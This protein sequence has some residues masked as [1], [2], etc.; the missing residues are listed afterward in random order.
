MTTLG[1][2]HK[3][4]VT[5]ERV[6][7]VQELVTV[8]KSNKKRWAAMYMSNGSYGVN[9]SGRTEAEFHDLKRSTQV[10]TK[11]AP[12]SLFHA[13]YRRALNRTQQRQITNEGRLFTVPAGTKDLEERQLI[14]S[15]LGGLQLV[16]DVTKDI[17]KQL[18]LAKHCN[19]TSVT[20]RADG[21]RDF[22]VALHH[23]R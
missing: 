14:L 10:H 13:D 4:T 20:L 22:K 8:L 3:G 23:F 1:R 11:A 15:N 12:A 17:V 18:H 19:V 6:R 21:L 2:K 5:G 7:K 9:E 16:D